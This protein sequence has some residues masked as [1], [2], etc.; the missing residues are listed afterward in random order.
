MTLPRETHRVS[1]VDR[2][3]IRCTGNYPECVAPADIC[4]HMP[5]NT[6]NTTGISFFYFCL[7]CWE[8]HQ[9]RYAG[10]VARHA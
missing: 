10:E 8:I 1:A 3:F 4:E 2:Q 5:W 9:R 6:G 7:P